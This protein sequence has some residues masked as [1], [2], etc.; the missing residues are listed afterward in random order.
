MNKQLP[1]ITTCSCNFTATDTTDISNYQLNRHKAEYVWQPQMYSGHITIDTDKETTM[2]KEKTRL[3][4]VIIID[5]DENVP[6]EERIL[7]NEPEKL[8]DLTN[9]ELFF[10]YEIQKT[11]DVHNTVRAKIIDKKATEKAGKDIYLE[12]IKIRDLRMV[13]VEIAVF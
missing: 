2:E 10:Q 5:P 3:V 7:I 11:L 4:R 1:T 6:L 12:P 9:Q 13:V 8:T